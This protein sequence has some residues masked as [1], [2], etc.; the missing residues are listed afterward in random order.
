[1]NQQQR[2]PSVT[3]YCRKQGIK[4]DAFYYWLHKI[5]EKFVGGMPKQSSGWLPNNLLFALKLPP[6]SLSEV[7]NIET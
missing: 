5:R 2:D 1:M 3:E 6:L 7:T 4:Y